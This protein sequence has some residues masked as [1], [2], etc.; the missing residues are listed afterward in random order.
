MKQNFR[1]GGILSLIKWSVIALW[2]VETSELPCAS[3]DPSQ[4]LVL[5]N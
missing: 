1:Y 3:L 2:L 4:V 5:V